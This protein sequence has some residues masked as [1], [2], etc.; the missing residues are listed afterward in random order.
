MQLCTSA[1]LGELVLIV[2]VEIERQG[3]G[4]HG[5]ELLLE[6]ARIDEE[7]DPAPRL[8][9][10]GMPARGARCIRISPR[11]AARA[12]LCADDRPYRTYGP[13][14]SRLAQERAGAAAE[15]A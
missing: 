4:A 9:A 5:S 14:A 7:V 13:D 8:Q 2:L 10:R 11:A 1:S 12:R 3:I 15:L 6:G